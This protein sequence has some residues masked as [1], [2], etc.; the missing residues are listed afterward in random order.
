MWLPVQFTEI[1]PNLSSSALIIV[2]SFFPPLGPEATLA[3]KQEDKLR[4]M[5]PLAIKIITYLWLPKS[6][7]ITYLS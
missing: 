3:V 2:S 4:C 5:H 6:P 7:H 1:R